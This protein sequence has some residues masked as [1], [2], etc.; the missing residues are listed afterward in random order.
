MCEF[1][2]EFL[3]GHFWE[4]RKKRKEE[5]LIDYF[6]KLESFRIFVNFF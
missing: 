1:D 2:E 6:I 4:D 3:I 5:R